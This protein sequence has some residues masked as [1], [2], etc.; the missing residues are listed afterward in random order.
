MNIPLS[1][2]NQETGIS[3]FFLCATDTKVKAP[4]LYTSSFLRDTS[5]PSTMATN[6]R[7]LCSSY[8]VALHRTQ[9]VTEHGLYQSSSQEAPEPNHLVVSFRSHQI[10]TSDI[11]KGQT[12]LT[13][14]P[15]LSKSSVSSAPALQL[16][17]CSHASP[18]KHSV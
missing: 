12:W 18:H 11:P 15:H 13:Q 8:Q 16:L 7:S 5:K 17:L 10:P 2:E 14:E 3:V 1:G 4:Q 9:A 6:F